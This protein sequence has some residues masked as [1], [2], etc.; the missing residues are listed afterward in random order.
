MYFCLNELEVGFIESTFSGNEQQM[1]YSS[2]SQLLFLED[3]IFL[4]VQL[5]GPR[6]ASMFR[7]IK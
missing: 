6:T 7:V 3:H 1:V 5:C 4:E 2:G